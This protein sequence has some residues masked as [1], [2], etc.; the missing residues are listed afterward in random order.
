M[1][2]AAHSAAVRARTRGD[3]SADGVKPVADDSGGALPRTA[4]QDQ[5][6]G[7]PTAAPVAGHA[8]ISVPVAAI[9]RGAGSP[10]A[11][12]VAPSVP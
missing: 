5:A 3:A 2:T 4:G 1:R 12:R 8:R 10:P 9:D 7:V 11:L 6:C